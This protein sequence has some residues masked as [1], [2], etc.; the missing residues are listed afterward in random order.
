M[1]RRKAFNLPEDLAEWLNTY[2]FR[3]RGKITQSEIATNALEAF[4]K[5][6][7]LPEPND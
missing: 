3:C 4:R 7:P 1:Y 6:H 2:V 5:D